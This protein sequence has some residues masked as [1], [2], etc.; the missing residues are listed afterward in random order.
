M[1]DT[2]RTDAAEIVQIFVNHPEL[3]TN[4]VPTEFARQLE[5]ELADRREWSSK[6]ADV[7]DDL[8][9]ELAETAKNYRCLAEL[10]DGHDATEC[11]ENLLVLKS[12][13]KR[14]EGFAKTYRL[15]ADEAEVKLAAERALPANLLDVHAICDQRDKALEDL[16]RERALADRLAASLDISQ[17]HHAE[18]T[19]MPYDEA[20]TAERALEAW[21]EARRG[22][23]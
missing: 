1:S 19:D 15:R 16:H 12:D 10:L 18:G 11:R 8:R 2:P 23:N 4:R 5:R 20:H 3:R 17:E 14:M 9:A 22:T 21:K 6:L 13:L 7:A